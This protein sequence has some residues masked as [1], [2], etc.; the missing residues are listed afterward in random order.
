MITMTDNTTGPELTTIVH[1]GYQVV[2]RS[3]D[4]F[5]TVYDSEEKP[6]ATITRPRVIGKEKLWRAARTD[7]TEIDNGF[8][9][10][11]LAMR[12][13]VR[14][15]NNPNSDDEYNMQQLHKSL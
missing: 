11:R 14:D 12:A 1:M 15:I 10:P 5:F 6:V 8:I 4:R 7:G 2:I 13:I 3:D 9:G